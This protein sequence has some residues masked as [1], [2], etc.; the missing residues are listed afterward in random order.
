VS[1]HIIALSPDQSTTVSGG[2]RRE[3]KVS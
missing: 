2:E 3:V 1:T